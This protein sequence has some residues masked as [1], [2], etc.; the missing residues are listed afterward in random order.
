MAGKVMR[1][2]GKLAHTCGLIL[3]FLDT[4]GRPARTSEI[5]RAV[6]K[7]YPEAA[8]YAGVVELHCAGRIKRVTHERDALY[9]L[10]RERKIVLSSPA[11]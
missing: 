6:V 10:K 8:V 3:V 7:W 1:P 11:T 2:I 9:V 4:I 5:A